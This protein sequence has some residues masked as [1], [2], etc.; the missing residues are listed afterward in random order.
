MADKFIQDFFEAMKMVAKSEVDQAAYDTTARGIVQSVAEDGSYIVRI[1]GA[2]RTAYSADEYKVNDVVYVL[3]PGGNFSAQLQIIGKEKNK[4]SAELEDEENFDDTYVTN[5]SNQ[6]SAN[7]IFSLDSSNIILYPANEEIN[8]I[9]F[10]K[11]KFIAY[12]KYSQGIQLGASFQTSFPDDFFREQIDDCN[13]GLKVTLEF[14]GNETRD[15]ILDVNYMTGFPFYYK[16][17]VQQLRTFLIEDAKDVTDVKEIVLF[18]KNAPDGQTNVQVSDILLYCL[19]DKASIKDNGSLTLFFDEDLK[20]LR[21]VLLFSTEPVQNSIVYSWYVDDPLSVDGWTQIS[22]ATSF[23]L[24][25]LTNYLYRES[26]QFKCVVDYEYLDEAGVIKKEQLSEEILV[27]QIDL[28]VKDFKSIEVKITENTEGIAKGYSQLII[29]PVNEKGEEKYVY[30]WQKNDALTEDQSAKLLIN[31]LQLD[32]DSKYVCFVYYKNEA[33]DF[34]GYIGNASAT[35]KKLGTKSVIEYYCASTTQNVLTLPNKNNKGDGISGADLTP[36]NYWWTE[37]T[38]TGYGPDARFL[39]NFEETTFT[40]E[41]STTTDDLDRTEPQLLSSSGIGIKQIYEF[42]AVT[43]DKKYDWGDDL[44]SVSWDEDSS[45]KPTVTYNSWT[46]DPSKAQISDAIKYLWNYEIILFINGSTQESGAVIIGA[47]GDRGLTGSSGYSIVLSNDYDGIPADFEGNV[48]ENGL[49]GAK[50]VVKVFQGTVQQKISDE[51]LVCEVYY[52]GEAD[53]LTGGYSLTFENDGSSATFTLLSSPDFI[54]DLNKNKLIA[55]FTFEYEDENKTKQ[56]ISSTFT[57]VKVKNGEPGTDYQL[58]VS[59]QVINLDAITDKQITLAVKP[60]KI[61]SNILE[62]LTGDSNVFPH[63]VIKYSAFA[64]EENEDYIFETLAYDTIDKKWKDINVNYSQENSWRQDKIIEIKLYVLF[65]SND[66]AD[67][68]TLWDIEKVALVWNGEN[69]EDGAQGRSVDKTYWEYAYVDPTQTATNTEG[70]ESGAD[71]SSIDDATEYILKLHN[72]NDTTKT[73]SV[74]VESVEELAVGGEFTY[75]NDTWIIDSISSQVFPIKKGFL[76][77]KR[78]ITVYSDDTTTAG[79]ATLSETDQRIV[80]WCAEQDSLFI[81]GGKLFAQSVTADAIKANSLTIGQLNNELT[82]A[83]TNQRNNL[84]IDSETMEDKAWINENEWTTLMDQDGAPLKDELGNTIKLSSNSYA[85]LYQEF[86]T[87]ENEVYT[88]SAQVKGDSFSYVEF[89]YQDLVLGT[90]AVL[91]KSY[92]AE[93]IADDAEGIRVY[94]TI[95]IGE[96]GINATKRASFRIENPS[97]GDELQISSICLSRGLNIAWCPQTLDA[98]VNASYSWKFSPTEGM[99]MWNGAQG[100]GDIEEKE[101]GT[102]I[103]PN[104]VFKIGDIK[105]TPQLYMRGNGE[106]TGKIIAQEGEIAGWSINGNSLFTLDTEFGSSGI[107]LY[108]VGDKNALAFGSRENKNWY[109]G[110]GSR[111]GVDAEGYIYSRGL[112]CYAENVKN[113]IYIPQYPLETSRD[114]PFSVS[115]SITLDQEPIEETLIVEIS[116]HGSYKVT[117]SEPI[118]NGKIVTLEFSSEETGGVEFTFSLSYLYKDNSIDDKLI[119]SISSEDGAKMEQGQ[120]GIWSINN[121]YPLTG[122]M[123]NSQS[124]FPNSYRVPSSFYGTE[125]QGSAICVFLSPFGIHVKQLNN[126]Q[127]TDADDAVS[128]AAVVQCV[129]AYIQSLPNYQQNYSNDYCINI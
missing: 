6:I 54:F 85:G 37:V 27:T 110:I 79:K 3:N 21:A 120:I 36:L 26:G 40:D 96:D 126:L 74:S 127:A 94:A 102:Y 70:W 20:E 108:P 109:L 60:E 91:V 77:Y 71:W 129:L 25:G 92:S 22:G 121:T 125:S 12:L 72:K 117:S 13:Y 82:G 53:K 67:D 65:E 68:T 69:G 29:T 11:S 98:N 105:G 18:I 5:G 118:L 61:Y 99:M 10:D 97:D 83:I 90:D 106:F 81:D 28:G 42:Y 93:E 15:Y 7:K 17:P 43:A 52:E 107:H 88:L 34:L 111:F 95:V 122:P 2:D 66:Q 41:D 84:Y 32:L 31:R 124:I 1:N 23:S 35:V 87:Q 56:S 45:E 64:K 86:V 113:G 44:P 14:S 58:S 9:G 57:M 62:I 123:S 104:L 4:L 55:T 30:R 75:Q 16:E 115:T 48:L 73:T 39:W 38:D 80:D 46:D 89:F 101:D 50:T 100:N 76:R 24:G 78:E 119:F 8:D 19:Q 103:D 47:Y 112:N 33:A 63:A 114:E 128:W 51:N 59:D 116:V 49:S